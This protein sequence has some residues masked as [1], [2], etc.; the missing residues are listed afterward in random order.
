MQPI[1]LIGMH[2]SGSSLLVKV[3]QELG[4]FMGNDFEENNESMFFS[5]INDWMLLQAG[6]SWDC[7]EN[8]NHISN[9]FKSLMVDIVLNRLKSIHL[10]KYLGSEKRSMKELD[11]TWGWKDPRNTFTINIWKEIFPEARVIHIYRNPIDV[12]NS[13]AKR[14]ASK[15]TVTGNPT[16]TGVKKKIYGY[17]LP[18]ERLF[19]HSFKSVNLLANFNLW[20][21]YVNKAFNLNQE[22]D[23]EVLHISYENLIEEP[24]AI[25]QSIAKFCNLKMDG[26]NHE[27]ILQ[28]IEK[29][30]KFAFVNDTELVEFYKTIKNN[31][32]AVRLG[33]ENIT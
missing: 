28:T 6:A 11:F 24:E 4:V 1:I 16:R 22:D 29:T 8:F 33:Y 21:T 26:M 18:K 10:K 7:P 9:D 3:L 27:K 19:Y 23:T 12:I 17:M 14:E 32:L 15:I 20:K 25:I 31:E 13:L 2:R 30:S 5:K